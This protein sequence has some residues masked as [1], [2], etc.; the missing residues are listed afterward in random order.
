MR[1]L[2]KVLGVLAAAALLSACGAEVVDAQSVEDSMSTQLEA[3]VGEVPKSVD[4]PEDISAEVGTEF[5]CTVTDSADNVAD[6]EA[7]ITD[8]EGTFE[9]EVV[10]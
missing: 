4:C 3:E 5:T 2:P 7:K 10:G 1:S 8:D 9:F 6:I